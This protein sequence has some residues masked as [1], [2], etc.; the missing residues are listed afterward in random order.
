ML[1][2]VINGAGASNSLTVDAPTTF[3]GPFSTGELTIAAGASV[4]WNPAFSFA[5]TSGSTFADTG[6]AHFNNS[7]LALGGGTL[8]VGGD[9]DGGSVTV[10]GG[11]LAIA[12]GAAFKNNLTVQNAVVTIGGDA[13]EKQWLSINGGSFIVGGLDT[14]P[15]LS[16]QGMTTLG[17]T[18][19]ND[20][21]KIANL[22]VSGTLMMGPSDSIDAQN[23][24]FTNASLQPNRGFGLTVV[25]GDHQR[26]RL[27]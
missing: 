11:A 15:S 1:P 22:N 19:G 3:N 13:D 26:P 18:F 14:T 20:T 2:R 9:A 16:T 7:T 23:G 10:S 6:D 27:R 25:F 17:G 4:S 12:G 24:S 5:L 21:Y 8:S